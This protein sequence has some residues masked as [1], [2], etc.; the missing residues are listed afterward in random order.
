MAR[1]KDPVIKYLRLSE[2]SILQGSQGKALTFMVFARL[3]EASILQ[4]SQGTSKLKIY[5]FLFG[6]PTVLQGGK[7]L[8]RSSSILVW[9]GKPTDL[10]GSHGSGIIILCIYGLAC[11]IVIYENTKKED[12]VIYYRKYKK[13]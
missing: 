10:Q 11:K 5:F 7:G 6:K 2:A 3:S 13:K 12:F 1:R 8:R 4:G 9:F